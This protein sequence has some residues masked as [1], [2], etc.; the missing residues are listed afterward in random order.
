[1]TSGRKLTLQDLQALAAVRGGSCLSES[2]RGSLRKHAWQC[3]E[4]HEW[5]A[6]PVSI[7]QGRWCPTCSRLRRRL[8][9]E[10][11]RNLAHERG[12]EL[13]SATYQGALKP[14]RWRCREGHG[15]EATPNHVKCGTWCPVCAAQR[16]CNSD[17]QVMA[18]QH[19]GQYLSCSF[20]GEQK[21][22]RWS[23]A[24]GHVWE[25][26]PRQVRAGIWCPEC[27]RRM[28]DTAKNLQ[29]H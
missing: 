6:T 14:L 23:C 1:V 2:C 19:G 22:H 5:E 4:G 13:L 8:T 7:H 28:G 12:G 3:S 21:V 26:S 17:L 10:S 20:N 11:L 18:A 29:I 15:W 25:A 24:Q 27:R 16:P 9:L